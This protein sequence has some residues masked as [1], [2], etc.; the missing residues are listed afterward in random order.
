MVEGD[1]SHEIVSLVSDTKAVVV[2]KATSVKVQSMRRSLMADRAR[3][4]NM[5][6]VPAG[7]DEEE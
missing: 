6:K 2:N 7:A 5:T 4:A 1:N 3:G